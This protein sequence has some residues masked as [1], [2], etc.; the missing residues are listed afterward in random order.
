[1]RFNIRLFILFIL[2]LN[3]ISLIALNSSLHQGGEFSG[4]EQ[5]Y[6][7]IVWIFVFWIV[8]VI[9]YF[10]NYRVYF[11][12]SFYIY[13]LSIIF[14]LGVKL[15]GREIM[16]AQRWIPLGGFNF[17]PSEFSKLAVIIL[18]ARML[19]LEVR[20]LVFFRKLLLPLLLI[21]ISFILIF[22]QPDLGTAILIFLI[23]FMMSLSSD[24]KKRYIIYTMIVGLVLLPLV[25]GK[26]ADY[27]KR[28]IIVF[29][30]PNVDP[31]G[32]G[33]T[34]IQSKIAIGSGKIFGKGFLAGTQ[35]QFNFLPERHT[36]FIF[37]VIAEE[38]GLIGSLFLLWIYSNIL[39]N[40]LN[41]TKE[42]KDNFGQFLCI[43]IFSLLFFQIFINIGMTMGLFPVVGIPLPFLSYGGTHLLITAIS[44]GIFLNIVKQW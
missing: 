16:G 15:W 13:I 18:S 31:L 1:M 17:Q 33:Y 35:N 24:I 3:A 40:I 44:L 7:Q 5:F 9:F 29:L 14:L 2:I 38:F 10:I 6:K 28:R 21:S 26:L 8:I 23:F 12:L 4:K 27:Q 37:T 30:D 42:V 39:K 43:G 20:K 36:D 11:N 25:W 19:S 22:K 34:I 41:K 32:A